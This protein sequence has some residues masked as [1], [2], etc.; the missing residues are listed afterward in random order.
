VQT[1][2][3]RRQVIIV[4]IGALS[5]IAAGCQAGAGVRRAAGDWQT[6]AAS[7]G[8]LTATVGATGT[9][10]SVQTGLLIFETSGIVEQVLVEVGVLVDDGVVLATLQESSLN[11]QVIL[12]RADLASAEHELEQLLD[13]ELAIAEAQLTL[14]NAQD[15]ADDAQRT[16]QYQQEGYRGSTITIEAAEAELVLAKAQLDRAERTAN[17][18]ADLPNDDPQRAQAFKDYAAAQTRHNRALASFNWYTGHP[19]EIYQAQLDAELAL[20]QA[21]AAEAEKTLSDL[22]SGPDLRQMEILQA[23]IDAAKAT[24]QMTQIV[25]P[26]QG[27]ITAAEI[28]PGDVVTPGTVAFRLSNQSRLL[29]DVEVSEV[30][31]NKIQTGQTATLQ[32]DAVLDRSY[33]GNVVEVGL[34]GADAQGIVNFLVTVEV[35]DPDELIK[36]GMTAA[37]TIEVNRIENVML[38]PNR[39]VRVRDG[40]RVVYLLQGEEPV[41]VPIGIGASSESYSVLENG[42][43]SSGDLIILNP[44]SDF[45]QNGSFFGRP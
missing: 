16:W 7:I 38:I 31:I 8:E 41:A 27:T 15:A 6:E 10:R 37:V 42:E 14:A 1:S 5:V 32:L 44:P 9:V 36:P 18:H 2:K 35:K 33:Q 40:E 11:A 4:V 23:R 22:Q 34:E 19:T 28:L 39:A 3:N 21:Q 20:A 13:Q 12:A 25:A 45:G 17:S 26:F 29:V 30:D 24:I 43:V